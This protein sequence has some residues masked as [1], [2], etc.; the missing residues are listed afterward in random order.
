MDLSGSHYDLVSRQIPFYQIA[1]HGLVYYAGDPVN[2]ADSY[3]QN[4]LKSAETGAGLYF[5]FAQIPAMELQTTDYTFYS[6]AL[7]ENW[8][9]ELMAIYSR[10]NQDFGH[11]ANLAITDHAY[12]TDQVTVTV[13]EDGTCV[14]VNYGATDYTAGGKT[15]KSMDYLVTGGRIDG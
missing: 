4:L 1:L 5:L 9:Q 14:Y 8:E 11:T 7:F 6:G 12:V 3:E 13:Y 2:L 15:V 10:Y